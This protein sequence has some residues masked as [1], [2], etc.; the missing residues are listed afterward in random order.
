MVEPI[1]VAVDGTA[2][3]GKSSICSR[4]CDE[5]SWVYVNT[6]ILYRAVAYLAG[7]KNIS[8][9]DETALLKVV[10]DFNIH[11][12]WKHETRRLFYQGHDISSKLMSETTGQQA[13]QL[14][15]L[16]RVRQA[17]LP[18]QRNLA[19]SCKKKVVVMEGRDI[20]TVVFPKASVKVFMTASIENRAKRRLEQL[21]G[22]DSKVVTLDQLIH[23]MKERDQEDTK[24]G[25]APLVETEDS[26]KFDTSSKSQND[27]VKDFI[28][29]VEKKLLE[30]KLLFN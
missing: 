13:S 25:V 23:Q 5:K 11:F 2:G 4:A 21:K 1:I 22:E 10:E 6:G 12:I 24:R 3:S 14:A 20:G 29:L 19:L 26:I 8:F 27:C 18:I 9:T 7:E 30:L 28:E 16:K 17:L 15:K